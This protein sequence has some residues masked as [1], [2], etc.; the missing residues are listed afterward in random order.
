[1][2]TLSAPLIVSI[3]LLV[4][5]VTVLLILGATYLR[6]QN[7][8]VALLRTEYPDEFRRVFGQKNSWGVDPFK[9]DLAISLDQLIEAGLFWRLDIKDK[10][11]RK[12]L[13]RL[14]IYTG[15]LV[16]LIPAILVAAA[17]VLRNART[18]V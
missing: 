12:L 15:L 3:P 2:P 14:R 9:A 16:L 13:T 11:Y 10:R 1:M 18:L 7:A 8:L 5:S 17:L 4:L 6:A